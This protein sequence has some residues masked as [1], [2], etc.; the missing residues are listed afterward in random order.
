M[1]ALAAGYRT[2]FTVAAALVAAALLVALATL[3]RPTRPVSAPGA[4]SAPVGR[5]AAAAV[6]EPAG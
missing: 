2:A 5:A 6:P 4:V 1:E 3:R